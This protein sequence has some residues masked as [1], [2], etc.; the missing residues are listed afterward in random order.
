M[1]GQQDVEETVD[2]D[3]K[4]EDARLRE[5]VGKPTSIRVEDTVVHIQHAGE[6]SS[7]ASKAAANADWDGW[8][9]EVILDEDECQAFKDANLMLYQIEAIF[10][11]CG[12]KGNMNSGKSK[13]SRR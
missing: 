10:E 6:W 7:A 12:R 11:V 2:L 5:A 9:D 8:A 3:L 13:R 4:A 1:S